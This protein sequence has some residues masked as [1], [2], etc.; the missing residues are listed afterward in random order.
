[1]QRATHH[2]DK[3]LVTHQILHVFH[4]VF[5]SHLVQED[6]Q[7]AQLLHVLLEILDRVLHIHGHL[8]ELIAN[9]EKRLTCDA[10]KHDV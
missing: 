8:R 2:I 10:I 6:I 3:H 5:P 4:Q 7:E 1:M 9:E